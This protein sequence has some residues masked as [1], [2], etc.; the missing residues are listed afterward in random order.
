MVTETVLS[1]EGSEGSRVG[2]G[3]KLNNNMVSDGHLGH[4]VQHG[5]PLLKARVCSSLPP[6]QSVMECRGVGRGVKSQW[7]SFLFYLRQ[8]SGAGA[9]VSHQQ[10][11][12]TLA[13]SRGP[14]QG[15]NSTHPRGSGWM[16]SLRSLPMRD[17][18]NLCSMVIIKSPI[19]R[20]R[21][22]AC[23]IPVLSLNNYLSCSLNYMSWGESSGNWL[24]GYVSFWTLPTA[25]NLVS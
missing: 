6:C 18:K 8:F 1:G 4:E 5:W 15:S 9:S 3:K 25:W 21:N 14:G 12:L 11:T 23:H 10:P 24:Q 19:S 17:G 7:K 20:L 22:S 13:W 16:F 2:P